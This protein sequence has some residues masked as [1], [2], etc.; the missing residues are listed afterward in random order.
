[1]TKIYSLQ[2]RGLTGL[3]PKSKTWLSPIHGIL[4]Q[5]HLARQLS[6]KTYNCQVQQPSMTSFPDLRALGLRTMIIMEDGPMMAYS[7]KSE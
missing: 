3:P 1:M 6:Q 4:M 2:T 7:D 5:M